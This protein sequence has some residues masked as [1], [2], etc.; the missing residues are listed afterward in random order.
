MTDQPTFPPVPPDSPSP[1]VPAPASPPAH[2]AA[3]ASART[4]A[5]AI[6]S[7]VTGLLAWFSVPLIFLVIPTPI[8]TVAAIICGH[9]ART[10]I[11]RDP[12]VQGDGFAIAGLVLGWAM[13]AS[14]VLAVVAV[15]LF[16]GGIAAFLAWAGMSGQMN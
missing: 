1:A 11:R 9:M 16:F 8:C 7:F 15:V 4:S 12:T 14:A 13:V 3:V 6:V 5:L 10:E 2:P